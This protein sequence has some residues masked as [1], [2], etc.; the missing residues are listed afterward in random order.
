MIHVNYKMFIDRK[1]IMAAIDRKRLKVLTQTGA[2]GRVAMQRQIRPAKSGRK[3]M[4]INVDGVDC[5]IPAGGRGLVRDAKTGHAVR[6]KLAAKA[7]KAWFARQREER[8]GQPPRRGPT[9]LLRKFMFF[10]VDESTQSV[11]IGPMAFSKQPAMT[12]AASVPELLEQGGSELQKWI[13]GQTIQTEYK[14]HP[15]AAPT[16]P[17]AERKFRELIESVPLK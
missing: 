8:A 6:K 4:T 3:A 5:I 13:D 17:V 12:G 15:F 11:V 10:G 9:D 2:Y 7:L 16:L 14:P 1:G